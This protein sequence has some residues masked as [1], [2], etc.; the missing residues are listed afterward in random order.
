MRDPNFMR[1]AEAR[2]DLS[3]QAGEF[4]VA[5]S[6][7]FWSPPADRPF[8]ADYRRNSFQS[9]AHSPVRVRSQK[10]LCGSVLKVCQ[11]EGFLVRQLP[12]FHQEG[13][14]RIVVRA[15]PTNAPVP[16]RTANDLELDFR[17]AVDAADDRRDFLAALSLK[18]RYKVAAT[19]F[20][21]SLVVSVVALPQ[22]A[23]RGIDKLVYTSGH[24][25]FGKLDKPALTRSQDS[26]AGRQSTSRS[27]LPCPAGQV[28][29]ALVAL[30][31]L[32]VL[33]KQWLLRKLQACNSAP[34]GL[35]DAFCAQASGMAR[36]RQPD[37]RLNFRIDCI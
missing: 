36:P 1:R 7:N 28:G 3:R 19:I 15:K 8:A 26:C 6:S 5:G 34:E 29:E 25:P 22:P 35:D 16:P 33:T 31:H 30:I 17:V 37:L 18:A 14:A 23:D 13:E 11:P 24:P 4:E 10:G 27:P 9:R 2:N 21:K 20:R 12:W 32:T